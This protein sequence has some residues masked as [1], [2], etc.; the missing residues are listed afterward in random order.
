MNMCDSQPTEYLN[1]HK[2]SSS[3]S[4]CVAG[5]AVDVQ[6]CLG[7]ILEATERGAPQ[8]VMSGIYNARAG[9][10]SLLPAIAGE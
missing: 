10:M 1:R 4:T 9:V 6:C 3:T 5:T 8:E 7:A 2:Q